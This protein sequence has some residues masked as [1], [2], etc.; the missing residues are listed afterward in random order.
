M[1]ELNL[2]ELKLKTQAAK[3]VLVLLPPEPDAELVSSATVLHQALKQSGKASIL[4]CSSAIEG[5]EEIKTAVGKQNLIISF[6]YKEEAVEHVSYD[7]DET[8]NRFNLIIRPKENSQ[9]LDVKSVQYNYTGAKADLVFVFGIASLEEL[10]KLYSD[11]KPFLDNA[12]IVVLKKG[13]QPADFAAF[14]LSGQRVLSLAELVIWFLRATELRLA[15]ETAG[16][17]YKQLVSST[18]NFQSPLITPE[19]FEAAA[20]LLRSGAR[21]F[22]VASQM[23]PVAAPV[24]LPPAPFFPASQPPQLKVAA[25]AVMSN[26]MPKQPVPADWQGPKIFRAGENV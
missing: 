25:P 13:G 23:P 18:N 15:P 26:P 6:P 14:D 17:L 3:S 12:P 16:S 22:P 9:P 21:T 19:T 24:N 2:D 5:N 10:G 20:Y 7:I 11:E 8:A 1:S 4:G